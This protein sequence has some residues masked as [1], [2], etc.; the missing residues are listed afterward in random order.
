MLN[1]ISVTLSCYLVTVLYMVSA[2]KI[3]KFGNFWPSSSSLLIPSDFIQYLRGSR[4]WS[5]DAENLKFG[6][7]FGMVG[8]LK[9]HSEVFCISLRSC[10][11]LLLFGGRGWHLWSQVRPLCVR[12][13]QQGCEARPRTQHTPSKHLSHRAGE[14]PKQTPGLRYRFTFTLQYKLCTCN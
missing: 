12:H 8:K 3:I 1:C 11:G 9:V 14:P 13:M 4:E 5:C 7:H 6:R 2:V 10:A